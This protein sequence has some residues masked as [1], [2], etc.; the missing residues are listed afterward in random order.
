MV[1]PWFGVL[2]S[3]VP[4]SLFFF[5]LVAL[6]DLPTVAVLI[7]YLCGFHSRCS[8][9]KVRCM[10]IYPACRI[11]YICYLLLLIKLIT[12]AP[13]QPSSR[14]IYI[15]A[16]RRTRFP[17]LDSG[18]PGITIDS[19]TKGFLHQPFDVQSSLVVKGQCKAR[20]AFFDIQDRMLHT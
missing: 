7:T 3:T 13:D 19:S 20:A 11:I 16:A 2:L 18:I 10:D 8:K 12:P 6:C 1:A 9:H 17:C 4:R 5:C 15:A 14:V